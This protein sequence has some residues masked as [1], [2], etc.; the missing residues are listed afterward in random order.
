[1]STRAKLAIIV[2][3]MIL[4]ATGAILLL[5][6][7]SK[8]SPP[9]VIPSATPSVVVFAD[10]AL[11]ERL[12]RELATKYQTFARSDDPAYFASIK[13]YITDALLKQTEEQDTRY[14]GRVPFLKPV[15]S[16]VSTI[17]ANG[18]GNDAMAEVRLDSLDLDTGKNFSQTLRIVWHK[19]GD[20][21]TATDIKTTEYG[22]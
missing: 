10:Q 15:R 1:M 7:H 14:A 22:K 12:S 18:Q 3:V 17:T 5:G 9:R 6:K 11:V 2:I 21:W 8:T 20:R 19:T 4:V 13:P 16:E